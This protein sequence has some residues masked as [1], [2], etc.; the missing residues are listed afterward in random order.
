M[1]IF[2]N[3]LQTLRP[4]KKLH[5]R[6]MRAVNLFFTQFE[7]KYGHYLEHIVRILRLSYFVMLVLMLWNM[8][9]MKFENVVL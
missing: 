4:T 6:S 8:I 2:I 1:K 7:G 3:L 5:K 9:M